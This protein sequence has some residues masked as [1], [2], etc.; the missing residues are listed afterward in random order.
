MIRAAAGLSLLLALAACSEP[1]YPGPA[2][3]WPYG[4][5]AQP[6]TLPPPVPI[7]PPPLDATPMQGAVAPLPPAVEAEPLGPVPLAPPPLAEPAPAPSSPEDAGVTLPDGTVLIPPAAGAPATAPGGAPASATPAAPS[8]PPP[9]PAKSPAAS[10][11]KSS[12]PLM[13]FRPMKGQTR[14]SSTP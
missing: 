12:I 9:A 3:G 6:G 4:A 13:G 11:D 10:D 14:P 7:A 8:P 2:Y 5:P 1:P